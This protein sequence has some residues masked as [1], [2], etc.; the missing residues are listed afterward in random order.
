MIFFETGGQSALLLHL[1]LAG[2]GAGVLYDLCTP[3]RLR[4]PAWLCPA[5]DGAWALAALTLC[6]LAM[7]QG[8][9]GRMRLFSLLGAGCGGAI[10][11]LGLRR[12]LR[13]LFRKA[14]AWR[15]RV[16]PQGGI[17]KGAE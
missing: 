17:D 10:Y 3:L 1:L 15:N 12:I 9:E 8:G 5:A 6:T 2:M 7:A 11:A 13:W 4:L 16:L 14:A